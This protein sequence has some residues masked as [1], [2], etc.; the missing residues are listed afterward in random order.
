MFYHVNL[1][2]YQCARRQESGEGEW[3]REGKKE[4]G[5]TVLSEEERREKRRGEISPSSYAH[6]RA[7]GRERKG[8]RGKRRRKKEDVA[9]R[10]KRCCGRE[11]EREVEEEEISLFSHTWRGGSLPTEKF[12]SREREREGERLKGEKE[13]SVRFPR[14][15]SNF[16][17]QETRGERRRKVEEKKEKSKEM[18][19]GACRWERRR[20]KRERERERERAGVRGYRRERR[21]KGREISLSPLRAHAQG[22]EGEKEREEERG[23]GE[24]G[25]HVT[26]KFPSHEWDERKTAGERDYERERRKKGRDNSPCYENYLRHEKR[27]KQKKETGKKEERRKERRGRRNLPLLLLHTRA[28]GRAMGRDRGREE[29]RGRE[30]RRNFLLAPCDGKISVATRNFNFHFNFN[31]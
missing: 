2:C 29:E 7:W 5:E 28:C 26:E 14:D 24:L 18:E 22:R 23:E 15:A 1:A 13:F 25:R 3:K 20:G 4:R 17:R 11:R 12:S 30:R 21:R 9:R 10:K 19:S 27:R 16:R 6:A 8:A 31:F